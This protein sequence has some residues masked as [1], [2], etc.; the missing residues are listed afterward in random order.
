M[1]MKKWNRQPGTCRALIW[2]MG[3]HVVVCH[4]CK[5]AVEMPAIDIP[6]DPCPFVCRVCGTRGEIKDPADVPA[7]YRS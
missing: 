1:G 3:R 6:F 7:D 2:S 5:R 4:P